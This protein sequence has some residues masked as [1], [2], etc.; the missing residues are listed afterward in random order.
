VNA[1]SPAPGAGRAFL[2]GTGWKSQVEIGL[3]SCQRISS[4]RTRIAAVKD[5]RKLKRERKAVE[6]AKGQLNEPSASDSDSHVVVA[7]DPSKIFLQDSGTTIDYN[8]QRHFPEEFE[9]MNAAHLTDANH[10][11][12]ASGS[13][14]RITA[15]SLRS[16]CSIFVRCANPACCSAKICTQVSL[17]VWNEMEYW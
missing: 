8:L 17:R 11:D 10:K 5:P 9:H 7:V 2:N 13:V 16:F 3:L 15:I 4:V 12:I 14:P 6:V 1:L